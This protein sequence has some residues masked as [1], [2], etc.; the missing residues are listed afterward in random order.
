MNEDKAYQGAGFSG[1]RVGEPDPGQLGTA[2]HDVPPVAAPSP[3]CP[4]CGS[5]L[6]Q[7]PDGGIWCTRC[8]A[9]IGTVAGAGNPL[10]ER[11][12][13]FVCGFLFSIFGVVGVALFSNPAKQG[14]RVLGAVIGMAAWLFIMWR[15]GAFDPWLAQ[16]GLNAH[17]CMYNTWTGQVITCTGPWSPQ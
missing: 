7:F 2:H 5:Q 6:Y 4:S 15:L 8:K 9:P 16:Y 13:G 14:N 3:A 10:L 11:F 1:T 12:Q 17:D